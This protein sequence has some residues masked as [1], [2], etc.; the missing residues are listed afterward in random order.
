M[1]SDFQAMSSGSEMA[2]LETARK[3]LRLDEEEE[4]E[5]EMTTEDI[6]AAYAGHRDQSFCL[7]GRFLTEKNINF[8]AMKNTLAS[9]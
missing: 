3:Q 4:G 2:G 7:L 6:A 1:M 5:M 9:V 8:L